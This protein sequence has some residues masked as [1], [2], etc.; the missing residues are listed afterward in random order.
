MHH[1]LNTPQT[2]ILEV[3]E[4]YDYYDFPTLFSCK[5]KKPVHDNEHQFYLVLFSDRSDDYDVWLYAEVTVDYLNLVRSAKVSLHDSFAN[6]EKGRL[7]KVEFPRNKSVEFNS[8]FVSPSELSE[9]ILPTVNDY[10]DIE[11]TP[12]IPQTS[13]VEIA[14]RAGREIVSIN[15]NSIE[16][17]N[18]EA[19]ILQL[20]NVLTCFQIMMNVIAMASLGHTKVTPR[21]RDEMQFFA[22]ASHPGS[23]ELKLASKEIGI[24]QLSLF[25]ES[26]TSSMQIDTISEFF[27]LIKSKNNKPDVKDILTRLGLRVTKEYRNLI[28]TFNKLQANINLSWTSQKADKDVEVVLSKDV[29]PLIAESLRN[30]TEEQEK[31]FIIKG[32]LIGLSLAT[33]KFEMELQTSDKP[34]KGYIL[35]D[36]NT[37][38]TNATISSMY[39]ATLREVL[40]KNETTDKIVRTD[41]IL[42]NLENI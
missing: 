7:L 28:T 26:S 31:P 42:L 3:I 21:I 20:G 8:E 19:S 39:Q 10:I 34:I 15:F 18:A 35:D 13:I 40:V 33:K 6:P 2:G 9:H 38:I 11:Y 41:H 27:K 24:K 12:L 5:S 37:N 25:D 30:I 29:I 16:E 17:Y 1:T 23:F 22:L 36:A 4:E 14:Q 32:R